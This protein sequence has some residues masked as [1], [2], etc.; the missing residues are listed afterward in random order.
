MT[1]SGDQ[2]PKTNNYGRPATLKSLGHDIAIIHSMSM[3]SKPISIMDK[4]ELVNRLSSI[5]SEIGSDS[6]SSTSSGSTTPTPTT[7]SLVRGPSSAKDNGTDVKHDVGADV[8][9]DDEDSESDDDSTSYAGSTSSSTY[10]FRQESFDTFKEK[11]SQLCKDIG[12]GE[13]TSIERMCGGSYHRVIGLHF[14]SRA[15]QD[16]VL[17]I[18]REPRDNTHE[19]SDEISIMIFASQLK[20]LRAPIVC[21]Y[22]CTTNNAIGC[23][24]VLQE[25][26]PGKPLEDVYY[27]LSLAEKLQITN[28][29]A[30]LVA[31]LETVVFDR[32]GR[33][34]G[35]RSIPEVSSV[36]PANE[37]TISITGFRDTPLE[38]E[39]DLPVLERQHLDKLFHQIFQLRRNLDD[40]QKTEFMS[41]HYDTL[42]RIAREMHL[43]GLTRKSDIDNVLWLWDMSAG[44][45]LIRPVPGS[46]QSQIPTW[47]ISGVLDWDEAKSV[48]LVLSRKP[49]AWLWVSDEDREFSCERDRDRKL[50]RDMTDDELLIKARFDQEMMK[51]SPSYVQDTY[52]RGLWLRRMSRFA[53]NGWVQGECFHRLDKLSEEWA[54]YYD[55]LEKVGVCSAKAS[56]YESDGESSE[57]S[58]DS[59]QCGSDG[60]K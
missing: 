14:A 40:Y 24:Y 49:P 33:L 10:R 8:K 19:T 26:L 44:N 39:I 11:V 6:S 36:P 31:N 57:E 3:S 22:D 13:P 58:D 25:R 35:N 12:Y 9:D 52:G 17:R 4:N 30:E 46:E 48:P 18:P 41:K 55:S 54:E 23:Q 37:S 34:I 38:L 21:A 27:E 7:N 16:F 50:G 53:I 29:V 47:E 60:E 56:L 2:T 5:D 45:I 43:A 28:L 20:F 42:E 1:G 32:P 15:Q 51:R 59:S